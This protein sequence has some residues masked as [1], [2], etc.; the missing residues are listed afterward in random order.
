VTRRELY[1]LTA[2][3]VRAWRLAKAAGAATV[4]SPWTARLCYAGAALVVAVIVY[5]VTR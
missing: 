2:P 3:R 1:V 4:S 5:V